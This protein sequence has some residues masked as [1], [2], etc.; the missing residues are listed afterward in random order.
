M[1]LKKFSPLLLLLL[2]FNF[3]ESL[4]SVYLNAG[5]AEGYDKYLVLDP[6][7]SYT[8]GIG[9]FE[10]SVFIEGNGAVIDLQE[11]SGIWVYGEGET[12]GTLDIRQCSILNGGFY[13]INYAGIASGSVVNCN[14]I[15]DNMGLQLMDTVMVSITNCNLI[16]NQTYGLAIYS[17]DPTAVISYCNAWNNGEDYMENCPG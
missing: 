3:G 9:V 15:N 11:G 12:V 17:T 4:F 14:L 7:I 13:G 5:P 10:G 2:A 1:I 6:D 8:G 16:A